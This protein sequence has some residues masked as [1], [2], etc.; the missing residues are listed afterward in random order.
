MELS[1]RAMSIKAST[2]MAISSKAAEM[3]AAGLPVVTFGAGEPD[4]DTPAHI[5]QAGIDA[6]ENGQTR[7]TAAAGTPALRQAVCD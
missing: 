6:I 2:T 7:Y 5:R 3:K 4:F 1:K